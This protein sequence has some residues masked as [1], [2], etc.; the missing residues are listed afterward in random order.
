MNT[1]E[2]STIRS[3]LP[4]GRTKYYYYKDRYALQLL[5]WKL[6]KER[7]PVRKLKANATTK[8]FLSK[9]PAKEIIKKASDGIL[10]SD[11]LSSYWPK[12]DKCHAFRLTVGQWGEESR[13]NDSW[14]QT[15]RAGLN[16]VLQLNFPAS[17]NRD[18]HEKIKMDS[19]NDPF[20]FTCHPVQKSAPYTLAWARLDIDLNRGVALIE[21]IQNDWLREAKYAYMSIQNDIASK[22]KNLKST[23]RHTTVHRFLTYYKRYVL[24]LDNIWD[25]ATLFASLWFLKEEIGI[26]KVYYHS[27]D[28]GLYYKGLKDNFGPPRSLYT[29][30]PKRFGFE[31]IEHG[32]AFIKAQKRKH[33]KGINMKWWYLEM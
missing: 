7:V 30:L 16:L 18:Y 23:W 29:K 9:S 32:P 26:S 31:K 20:L 22:K 21:E 17:H 2:L 5:A 11:Q 28:S 33:K 19:G 8:R 1:T 13:V 15:S 6:G 14:F 10:D 3:R 24:A 27:W 12:H 4:Q 25:E